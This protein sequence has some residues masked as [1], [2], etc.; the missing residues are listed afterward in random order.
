MVL[1]AYIEEQV[2]DEKSWAMMGPVFRMIFSRGV[3]FK[4]GPGDNPDNDRFETEFFSLA[5]S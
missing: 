4:I 5:G 2:F 1:R 3:R